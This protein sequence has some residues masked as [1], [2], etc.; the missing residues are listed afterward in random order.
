[1][2]QIKSDPNDPSG[3]DGFGLSDFQQEM[4]VSITTAGAI[5]GSLLAGSLAE[6]WGRHPVL[7][8][9]SICFIFGAGGMAFA[10]NY[11]I[12]L[13]GRAVVGLSVGAASHTV[14]LYL[15]E[16]LV[17]CDSSATSHMQSLQ[18]NL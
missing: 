17:L 15:A 9:A 4:I 10:P 1:M 12:L 8:S 5:V 18:N 6:T 14:P 2:I 13:V 7:T 3:V 11:E 16:V